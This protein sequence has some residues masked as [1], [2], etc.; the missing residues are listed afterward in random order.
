MRGGAHADES[1]DTRSSKSAYGQPKPPS[2][3]RLA[4]TLIYTN[5]HM[6][7]Q[8]AKSTLPFAQ[9]VRK[10]EQRVID[11]PAGCRRWG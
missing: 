8:P 5:T 10:V 11:V 7:I 3:E 9:E 2:Q 6:H 1:P 4:R